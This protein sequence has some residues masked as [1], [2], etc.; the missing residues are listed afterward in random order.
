MISDLSVKVTDVLLSNRIIEKQD[1]DIY[2]YGLELLM[3]TVINLTCIIFIGCMFGKFIQTTIFILEYCFIRRYAGGYHA[4]THGRCIAAFSIL[5]FLM[6]GITEMFHINEANLILILASIV[7]NI[8]VFQLSPVA[9][10]NK[11]LEDHEIKRNSLMSKRLVIISLVINIILY[12]F[13]KNEYSLVLFALY[14]QVWVGAVVLVG[15]IKNRY[16]TKLL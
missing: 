10:Q 16:I 11:P 2:K 9:D 1:E 15:Y 6:L 13:F 14:A 7:S 12:L 8:I 3:S 5:Y 4:D